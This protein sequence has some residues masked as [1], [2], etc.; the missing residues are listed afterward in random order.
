MQDV[1]QEVG[2]SF[3]RLVLSKSSKDKWWDKLICNTNKPAWL[4]IDFD[5]WYDPFAEASDSESGKTGDPNFNLEE[6]EVINLWNN[7]RL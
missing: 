5:R 1:A 2:K 4:K 7:F 3:V 6:Y